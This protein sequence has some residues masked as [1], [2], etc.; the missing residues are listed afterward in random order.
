MK[1][2]LFII[3]I[4]ILAVFWGGTSW[5]QDKTA[6]EIFFKEKAFT[7]DEVVEGTYIEH[8]Y[9]VYNRGNALLKIRKVSPG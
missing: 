7:A 6:P 3:L 9:P 1:N 8:T 4:F 5:G 2:R